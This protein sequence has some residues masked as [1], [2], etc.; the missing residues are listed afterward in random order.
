MN[1]SCCMYFPSFPIY[2]EDVQFNL[3]VPTSKVGK[4]NHKGELEN[5][6]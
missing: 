5:D 4:E 2:S 6:C 1:I 3:L